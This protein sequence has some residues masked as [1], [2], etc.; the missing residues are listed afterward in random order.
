LQ[1]GKF[2]V[3]IKRRTLAQGLAA[4]VLGLGVYYSIL[5]SYSGV[6]HATYHVDKSIHWATFIKDC[7]KGV[8]LDAARRV[9]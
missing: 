3:L 9:H 8:P 1:I 5:W 7:G 6:Q 2:G 4:I